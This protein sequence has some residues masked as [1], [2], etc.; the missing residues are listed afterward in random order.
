MGDLRHHPHDHQP[1]RDHNDHCHD[2]CHDHR[3]DHNDDHHAHIMDMSGLVR[4]SKGGEEE[5]DRQPP[6]HFCL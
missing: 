2:H 5:Y 1:Y 6:T 3:H 4:K